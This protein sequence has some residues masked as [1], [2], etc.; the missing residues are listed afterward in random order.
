LYFEREI[1]GLCAGTKFEFS[2]WIKD[3]NTEG[4]I[5]PRVRFEIYSVEP[6]GAVGD[7]LLDEISESDY[8]VNEWREQKKE[9]V[10]PHAIGK[11]LLRISNAVNDQQGNDIAI[12]DIG[13]RPMGPG[14]D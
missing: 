7:L 13:F 8:P 1:E 3:V 10:M 9:F 5:Q 11:I 4:S 6:N 12:D 14:L 2:A